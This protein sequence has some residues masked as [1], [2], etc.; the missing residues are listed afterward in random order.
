MSKNGMK[1]LYAASTDGHLYSFHIPYLQAMLAQG[2]QIVTA[3]AGKG[4]RLPDGLRH[5]EV[6]FTKSFLSA[7]NLQ[8]SLRLAKL[9]RQERFDLILTHTSLA[10]FFTRLAVR[11][12]G[13]KKCRVVN[14]VHGYLFD[15][16]SAPLRRF[17]ML[18]AEKL[19]AGVTDDILTM[20]R[21]D[22]NIAQKHRLCRGRVAAIDG[23]GLDISR[24]IPA[25]AEEKAKARAALGLPADALVLL[26]AAE[27]SKRKNQRMLL[28]AMAALPKDVWLLLPGRGE[29]WSACKAWAEELGI[30]G[31][32]LF[33][34]F[35]TD[36]RP[37]LQ[38]ADLGVSP[39][40]SEGLPFNIM[41]AMAAG[42]PCVLSRV[43]GH[44][45]L[46]SDG[47]N[48]FMFLFDD[49]ESFCTGVLRLKEDPQLRLVM[50]RQ[51]RASV[52]RYDRA[53][54]LPDVM[55]YYR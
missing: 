26:Y 4:E 35:V 12:A 29:L 20:N 44:E 25:T 11:L 33:P 18:G 41:E 3:S 38:A 7:K 31:R 27:F 21:Q 55:S 28:E 5:V 16:N 15:E 42:L 50:G 22:Q 46:I 52:L 8:A 48:G 24:F 34:G 53:R 14:V 6:G 51:A 1:I 49:V 39:S 13:K 23:M 32:V 45:D 10:A 54:V 19:M 17:I 43:K 2:K 9:I 30:A 37:W 40:R 47:M 36:L